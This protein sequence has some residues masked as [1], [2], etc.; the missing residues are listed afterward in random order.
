MVG[1]LEKSI[2]IR[3]DDEG[4]MNIDDDEEEEDKQ[5]IDDE[6]K[7]NDAMYRLLYFLESSRYR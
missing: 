3:I 4:K 6:G 1:Y 7:C 2:Y 5:K